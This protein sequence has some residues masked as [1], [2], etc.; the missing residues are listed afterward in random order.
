MTGPNSDHMDALAQRLGQVDL[1][2][3]QGLITSPSSS[4]PTAATLS[5]VDSSSGDASYVAPCPAPVEDVWRRAGAPTRSALVRELTDV[6]RALALLLL[7]LLWQRA[8]VVFL[9]I[10]F[11]QIRVLAVALPVVLSLSRGQGVLS[12]ASAQ[13]RSARRA[14]VADA[15]SLTHARMVMLVRERGRSVTSLILFA[16]ALLAAVCCL[17][18]ASA[19]LYFRVFDLH[20]G[21]ALRRSGTRDVGGVLSRLADFATCFVS[22][23]CP[24]IIPVPNMLTSQA[25]GPFQWDAESKQCFVTDLL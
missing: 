18:F 16:R 3:S 2:A 14:R 12:A 24:D 13:S 21:A 15:K 1:T 11:A 19:A 17:W 10:A 8:A 20:L 22:D 5:C 4:T 23:G 6:A 25:I 7:P 9:L